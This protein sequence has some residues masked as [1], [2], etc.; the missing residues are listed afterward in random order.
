[1]RGKRT[2]TKIKE[3]KGTFRQNESVKNEMQPPEA[4]N[5]LTV[6]LINNYATDEWLKVTRILSN[7][8]MLAETDTSVLLAYCNEIGTYFQCCDILKSGGF[9]FATP[10]GFEQQRP[11]V[12]IGN[13]SLQNAI[14]LSDKFGF[15]PAARTKIEAPTK[16]DKDPFDEL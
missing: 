6:G 11:E 16:Q 8:G 9:T 14:K 7:L 12:L 15:N 10:N 3:L 2:P 4:T 13:K 1:M 5:E